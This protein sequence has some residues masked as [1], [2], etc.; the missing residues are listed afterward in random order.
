[1]SKKNYVVRQGFIFRITR[2]GQDGKPVVKEYSAGDTV[3]LDQE[4]GDGVHQLEYADEADRAAA[5]KAEQKALK[6]QPAPA[7]AGGFD[8]DA[9]AA[10]IAA[11]VAQALA[12]QAPAAS[13][14]RA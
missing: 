12:A 10:A 9:L 8:A 1:M 3:Q 6:A 5:L 13:A 2:P 4:E 7:G 14:A 11:G